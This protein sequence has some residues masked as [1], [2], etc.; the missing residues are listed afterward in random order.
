MGCNYRTNRV[1]QMLTVDSVNSGVSVAT[2]V[3]QMIGRQST[4]T[5]HPLPHIG[6][7]RSGPRSMASMDASK[8]RC[9][10]SSFTAV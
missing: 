4:L 6:P 5:L 2:D 7:M 8:L 3:N 9:I 1:L 10:R